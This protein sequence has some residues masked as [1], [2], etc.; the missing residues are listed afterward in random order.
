VRLLL[1]SEGVL[2]VGV[3]V[4]RGGA[5]DDG[6][7]RRGAVSV[8]VRRLLE[9][10]FGR[11]I[12]DWEIE[13]AILPRVHARSEVVSGYPRKVC[14][15]IQEAAARGCTSVAIVIDRDR[16][17]SGARLRELRDGRTLAEQQGEPLAYKS[18]VGVAIETVEAWLL[19]DEKALNDALS[20]SPPALKIEDPEGLDGGPKTSTYPKN[21][22][23]EL[24][25]RSKAPT[26][27][28]YDDVAQRVQLDVLESRCK[29]GFAP[30]AE[31]VRA[32][33]E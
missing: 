21:V 1:V 6:D 11:D 30:F 14:L 31:D 28:P 15:A 16:T 29:G 20:L 19:A 32:R 9:Q 4:R 2:D 22:F 26:K 10:K 25:S 33:C 18:A 12:Q 24:M 23:R 3:A 7:E 8:L 27:T 13:S 17:E 5:H